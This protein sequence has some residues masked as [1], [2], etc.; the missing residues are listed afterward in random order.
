MANFEEMA[1]IYIHIPFCVQACHYC[2]FHFSTQRGNQPEMV[3]ALCREIVLRT[4][5]L[6]SQKI[7]TI[8]FGG[9]TPSVLTSSQI[10]R[11]LQTIHNTFQVTPD[12]EVTLEANPD[13]LSQSKTREL[14]LSGI[15]RLSIGIQS[16]DDN[17]LRFLHRA[18]DGNQSR[19]CL[20]YVR[21]AGFE[22]IS[23]DLIFG[24]PGRTGDMLR[25]DLQEVLRWN[26]EHLSA[27]GLTIEERTVFGKQHARGLFPAVP[28][29]EQAVQFEQV[30]DTLESGGYRH[31]EVSNFSRPGFHARHN[32]SYWSG[33]P[34]L[35][36]GPGAH[37]FD[38]RNT[39][40]ANVRDNRAYLRALGRG[41]IPAEMETLTQ[42]E[43]G[44]EYL[45]TSLRTAAGCDLNWLREK[46]GYDLVAEHSGYLIQL[47][48]LGN[49]VLQDQ[50]LILTRKGKMIADRIAGDLFQ[51]ES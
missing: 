17:V 24:I 36:I 46:F 16:F 40:Q 41:E 38:G 26:P 34:Y 20:H 2:D 25:N 5:Y 51:A 27:Y 22:N 8:Y 42:R 49:A 14:L 6:A 47:Q 30:I 37:S 48:A 31:Y 13:D 3:E 19:D 29:E 45:M 15:N 11:L 18:H 28:E 4:D 7:E 1:G 33:V 35:G 43:R 12:A 21:E 32:S 50:H 44:N 9:G 23:L 10:D 39:R